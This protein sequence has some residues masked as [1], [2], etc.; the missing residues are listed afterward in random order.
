MKIKTVADLRRIPIGTKLLRTFC[1]AKPK[2]PAQVLTLHAVTSRDLVFTATAANE[3]FETF[4]GIPKAKCLR[5]DENGFSILADPDS[6]DFEPPG[7][8]LLSYSFDLGY[9]A[10]AHGQPVAPSVPER[11][12]AAQQQPTAE[13]LLRHIRRHVEE[14]TKIIIGGRDNANQRG[15]HESTVISWE[16]AQGAAFY[17]TVKELLDRYPDIGKTS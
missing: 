10:P 13:D 11:E 15:I 4:L 2:A 6:G 7:T 8:V 17:A 3:A 1:A 14:T 5:S 16:E 12:H 9:S